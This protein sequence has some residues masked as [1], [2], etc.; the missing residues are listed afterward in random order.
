[1]PPCFP[2]FNIA[3]HPCPYSVSHFCHNKGR[4]RSSAGLVSSSKF[5]TL[6]RNRLRSSEY[7]AADFCTRGTHVE[8]GAG[9]PDVAV[10]PGDHRV[11]DHVRRDQL[12]VDIALKVQDEVVQNHQDLIS[13]HICILFCH[14]FK[15][16]R[17]GTN[18][19]SYSSPFYQHLPRSHLPAHGGA[20][21]IEEGAGRTLGSS[22]G[23]PPARGSFGDNTLLAGGHQERAAAAGRTTFHGLPPPARLI[24]KSK[25]SEEAAR[26]QETFSTKQTDLIRAGK[27]ALNYLLPKRQKDEER[28][29]FWRTELRRGVA[30]PVGWV[31]VSSCL[32]AA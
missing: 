26:K 10:V 12:V 16:W 27:V 18:L 15:A 20:W 1:M 6:P 32:N 4:N 13:I 23:T 19:A 29:R 8:A 30:Y 5:K 31:A 22:R 28:P 9:R 3:V 21:E 25:P 17:G 2:E 14:H 24:W 11:L 7:F